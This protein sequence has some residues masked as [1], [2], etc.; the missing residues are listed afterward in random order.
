VF[1]QWVET[2]TRYVKESTGNDSS[3]SNNNNAS[4]TGV[5]VANKIDLVR[6][7]FKIDYSILIDYVSDKS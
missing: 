2:V 3:K 5:I 7:G 1:F 6:I 4:L